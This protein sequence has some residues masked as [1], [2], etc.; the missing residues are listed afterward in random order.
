IVKTAMESRRMV[1]WDK[2]DLDTVGILKVD[3]LALG[4]LTC[5]KHAF[6]LLENHY[7]VRDKYERRLTLATIPPEEEKVYAMICRADTLGVFQIESRAQM[8]MLPRLKP[9]EFYDLV[10]EVAIV[11][12][13]PIQGD[14]VHPYLRRRMGKEKVDYPS[15]ALKAILKRTLGVPLFQEQAMKIAIDAGGFTPGEADQLRRAMATFKRNGT[16]KDYED[17]MIEG[18]VGNNYSK[19]FAQRCFNQI[20]GFGDYGFPESHAASFALLVYASCWFKTFYPD[21]FCAAILNSQPMG[22]YAPA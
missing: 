15:P 3:V 21:V 18:M 8:S 6:N 10:I 9:K 11:R 14:M 22:F 1:E 4:M 12:P 20:K 5:L 17:R 19:E 13:G 16:I 2:D 7:R